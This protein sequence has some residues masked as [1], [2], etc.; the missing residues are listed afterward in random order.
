MISLAAAWLMPLGSL[1]PASTFFTMYS[2]DCARKPPVPQQG[3]KTR[4][5]TFGSRTRTMARMT[6][7]GVKNWPAEVLRV[8]REIAEGLAAAHARGLVHRDI[9]PANVWLEERRGRV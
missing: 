7:R 4:S 6:S 1:S 2:A 5:P 9:K 8:G 3:S